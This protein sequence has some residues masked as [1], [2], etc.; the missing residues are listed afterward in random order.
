MNPG[1]G[2][3]L[4]AVTMAKPF[5]VDGFHAAHIGAAVLRHGYITVLADHAGHGIDPQH[6]ITDVAVHVAVELFEKLDGL[7]QLGAGW[8]NEFQQRFGIIRGDVGVRKCGAQRLSLIYISE[9]TRL[10]GISYAVF[11]L[12]KKT[13]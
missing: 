10:R 1:E 12:K 2:L 4:A 6:F 8:G 9:P 13:H 11:C 3:H 7:V 5:P